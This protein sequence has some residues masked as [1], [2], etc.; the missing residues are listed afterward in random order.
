MYMDF[1]KYIGIP[2]DNK[3]KSK[4]ILS[5]L[6]YPEIVIIPEGSIVT[7]DYRPNRYRIFVNNLEEKIIT[8]IT[9]G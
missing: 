4:I 2:Y 3:I 6:N 5:S 9:Q 7:A 1:E 8:Y